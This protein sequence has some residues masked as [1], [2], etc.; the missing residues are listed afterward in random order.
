MLRCF[1]TLGCPELSLDDALALA[2]RHNLDAIELRALGGLTDLPAYFRAQF[3][4]PAVLG[5]R[6]R[7][8]RV[9]IVALGTSW[10]LAGGTTTE[11]DE[12]LEY[13]PWAE[14]AGIPWLRVFDGNS[15]GDDG[16]TFSGAAESV[17]WWR[18][19]RRKRGVRADIMIETHDS[20]FTGAAIMRFLA[21]APDTAIL[22]D[23]H[24]TWKKGGEDPLKTW[25]KIR[26]SVV[27]VH[28]KDSTNVPSA[29]HPW[30]YVL[31]GEGGFP[32]GPVIAAL[33]AD[34]FGGAVSLEW[35]KLWHPYLPSLEEALRAAAKRGW[36]GEG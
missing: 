12:F 33:K 7:G 23:T 28:L 3:G 29:K 13:L 36:M 19:I 34:K 10:H 6:L 30:T 16:G 18:E 11:R 1:S 15:P 22:W 35:E 9:R 17:R 14:A 24:H 25:R 4:S 27:H 32:I 31:P 20:L 5:K 2:A 21:A 26:M 8:E